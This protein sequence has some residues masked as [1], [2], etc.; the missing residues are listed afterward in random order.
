M[1]KAYFPM[2]IRY[3]FDSIRA[4]VTNQ[5]CEIDPRRTID[6]IPHRIVQAVRFHNTT[7]AVLGT[8]GLI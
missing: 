3:L 5:R 4:S 2:D 1:P 8:V 6:S 7:L